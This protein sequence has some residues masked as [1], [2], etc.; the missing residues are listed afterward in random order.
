MGLILNFGPNADRFCVPNTPSP[1]HGID[2]RLLIPG[3]ELIADRAS[4]GKFRA[5]FPTM[6]VEGVFTIGNR[7]LPVDQITRQI[8]RDVISV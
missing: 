8:L 2:S 7:I 5:L 3:N 1:S 6:N 4:R